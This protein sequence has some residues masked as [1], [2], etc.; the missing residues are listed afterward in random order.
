[1]HGYPPQVDAI[2]FARREQE[3]VGE[4]NVSRLQRLLEGLPEQP[5]SSMVQ[6]KLSGLRS[7]DGR[8]RLSLGVQTTIVLECQRCLGDLA[9]NINHQVVLELVR[10][11]SELDTDNQEEDD[12][13]APEKI[14]GS[15]R[16]DVGELIEDELILEV[17]YVPKHEACVVETSVDE[18]GS[19]NEPE[20]AKRPSP[21]AVLGQLNMKSK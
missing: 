6:Y 15:P 12:P 18:A 10:Q 13:D 3:I 19:T 2:E 21:F 20:A 17:P 9:L 1:M 4:F 16:F 11:A 8:R 14:V 5:D 7:L